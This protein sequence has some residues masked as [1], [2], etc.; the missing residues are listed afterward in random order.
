MKNPSYTVLVEI[1]VATLIFLLASTTLLRLFTLA[2]DTD[3]D[4]RKRTQALI[5][6]QDCAQQLAAQDGAPASLLSQGYARM[7]DGAYERET[8]DGMRIR[9]EMEQSQTLAGTLTQ[10]QI[11][12]LQGEEVLSQLPA[13]GYVE[14]ALYI[15]EGIS[16]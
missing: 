16:P 8:Q 3:V 12:V 6:A 7:Q 5:Y 15:K 10:A 11:T 4:T 13:A 1:S 9:V 14:N 2:F